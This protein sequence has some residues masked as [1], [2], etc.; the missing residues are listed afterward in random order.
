MSGVSRDAYYNPEQALQE[1]MLQEQLVNQAVDVQVLLRILVDKEII[2]RDEVA[3]YREEV[4][5]SPKYANTISKIDHQKKGFEAAQNDPQ[6]YMK[7]L[8]KA[9][10]DGKIK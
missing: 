6:G 5:S 8:L 7:A 9:K 2:T 1:L 3:K 10:L 4:R